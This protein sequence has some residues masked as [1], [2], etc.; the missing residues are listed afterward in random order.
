[1]NG[2][3]IKM[4]ELDIEC[5]TADG[6]P[7]ILIIDDS[8]E[9]I[10]SLSALL[11]DKAEILFATS[12]E[13]GIYIANKIRPDLI[14]LDV[15]MPLMDGFEVCR[16]LKSD[17]ITCD[18]VVIFVTGHSNSEHEVA[19]LHAG[20]IDFLSKPL[21]PAVVRARVQTHLSLIEKTKLLTRLAKY[22]GLT[23]IYNRRYFDTQL[24]EELRRHQRQS[25]S[26][27][28]AIV[29]IDHFKDY[30][31]GYGHLRG[32]RWWR[33]TAARNSRLSSLQ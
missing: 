28:L 2:E 16:R 27:G 24:S 15:E 25:I 9:V 21:V 22:D 12:P 30:N 26:L 1:L 3:G 17:P 8:I 18:S 19:A 11:S 7:Q 4:L 29:D 20:A 31:D 5:Q 13:K 23:G 6:K 32:D 33:A 10:R 14:L